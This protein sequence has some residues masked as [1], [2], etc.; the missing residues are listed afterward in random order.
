MNYS[1]RAVT[2][3]VSLSIPLNCSCCI[4]CGFKVS[5]DRDA[6]SGSHGH[7]G[8]QWILYLT[9]IQHVHM[10]LF[11]Q[12]RAPL[13]AWEASG[14]KANPYVHTQGP[15][16]RVALPNLQIDSMWYRAVRIFLVF[17]CPD[18]EPAAFEVVSNV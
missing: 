2:S 13:L 11:L 15:G 9:S 6:S 7:N 8:V 18:S 17:L 10:A 12:S 5:A 4:S 1:W 3:E 14:C 16:Q